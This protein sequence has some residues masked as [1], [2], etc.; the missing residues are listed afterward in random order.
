[1]KMWQDPLRII[2]NFHE[3]K[4]FSKMSSRQ[5][6]TFDNGF[7]R[8]HKRSIEKVQLSLMRTVSFTTQSDA[9]LFSATVPVT[10]TG[11][12]W[13]MSFAPVTNPTSGSASGRYAFVIARESLAAST[14]ATGDLNIPYVPEE[15]VLVAGNWDVGRIAANETAR[16]QDKFGSTKTQR[17]LKCG[18]TLRVLFKGDQANQVIDVTGVITFFTK[19]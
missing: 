9:Q 11:L 17:K 3:R 6:R 13:D 2:T 14:M 8:N 5:K 10:I 1:M 18:D 15:N 4:K 16:I 7:R 12:H 19:F